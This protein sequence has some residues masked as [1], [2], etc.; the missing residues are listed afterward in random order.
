MVVITT[1]RGTVE[2][3]NNRLLDLAVKLLLFKIEW[4]THEL[5]IPISLGGFVNGF[6]TPY[7][8]DVVIE[9]LRVV[10]RREMEEFEEAMKI[11]QA[12]LD[13]KKRAISIETQDV[14]EAFEL[15]LI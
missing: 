15:T 14:E 5:A 13:W 2:H 7:I 10:I 11:Q 1:L 4:H 8:R 9:D 6:N 12:V 3:V